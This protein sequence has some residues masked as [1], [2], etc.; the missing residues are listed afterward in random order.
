MGFLPTD[1]LNEHYSCSTSTLSENRTLIDISPNHLTPYD[2]TFSTK[3]ATLELSIQHKGFTIFTSIPAIA[4]YNNIIY[5][6]QI[7]RYGC[8]SCLWIE[9]IICESPR[10]AEVISAVFMIGGSSGCSSY[11][12]EDNSYVP[13]ISLNGLIRA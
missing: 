6:F 13:N 8:R 12:A 5:M 10:A 11:I 2:Y 9:L 4:I 1:Q 3:T 7:R